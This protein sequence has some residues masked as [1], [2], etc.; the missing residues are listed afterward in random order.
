MP[1]RFALFIVLVINAAFHA[2]AF[3]QDSPAQTQEAV[4]EVAPPEPEV[5]PSAKPA[6]PPAVKTL[7]A[8]QTGAAGQAARAAARA[9]GQTATPVATR[10]SQSAVMESQEISRMRFLAGLNKG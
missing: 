6:A 9:A 8:P 1:I 4:P 2:M 3:A 10:Q 5:K 7:P